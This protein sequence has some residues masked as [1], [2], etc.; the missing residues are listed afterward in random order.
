M[1][2]HQLCTGGNP[3]SHSKLTFADYRSSLYHL[4]YWIGGTYIST[5]IVRIQLRKDSLQRRN[6]QS[7]LL[8]HTDKKS[9]ERV[10]YR[11]LNFV[12][13]YLTAPMHLVKCLFTTV[14]ITITK[15]VWKE[16]IETIKLNW[17]EL[18]V[19]TQSCFSNTYWTY[20]PSPIATAHY[21]LK[22]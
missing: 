6:T 12:F 5:A 16:K 7:L 15:F 3:W 8:P 14:D 1:C 10:A 11:S 20:H 2:V 18:W 9:I 13:F 4:I 21:Y 17:K 22:L 19:V